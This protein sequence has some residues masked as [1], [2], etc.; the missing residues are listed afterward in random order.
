MRE[1]E[2]LTLEPAGLRQRV[3]AGIE[4]AWETLVRGFARG[5]EFVVVFGSWLLLPLWPVLAAAVLRDGD[6][7]R[8]YRTTVVRLIGHI[9]AVWNTRAISRM[10]SRG[11]VPSAHAA[12]ERVVGN[13]THCGK[14][15][16]DHACVFLAFD[17][18]GR[19]RCTI[20]GTWLWKI[21]FANCGRYPVDG[22]EIVLYGCPGFSSVREPGASA[23]RIIPIVP[24]MQPTELES[25]GTESPET[26]GG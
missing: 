18:A 5:V 11:L 3:V 25:I 8:R 14:C 21:M 4:A 12:P 13:C 16:L 10:V 23:R 1:S 26:T 2:A 9:R 17:E 6:Y 24:A 20:Y 7:V 19:S 15:C 22:Q